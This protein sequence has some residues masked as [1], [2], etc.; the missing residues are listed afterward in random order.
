[1]EPW[2]WIALAALMLV[3]GFL[4]IER[5]PPAVVEVSFSHDDATLAGTLTLP[6]GDGPHPA[7]ILISGSGPQNRDEEIPGVPGYLPFRWIADHLARRGVAVLRYD[8]RGVG[9]S[10]GDHA[11]AT[12][13]DFADDAEAAF[14]YLQGRKEIDP[15]QV[16]FLGH[17][18]GA[19]VA[20]MV[21]ARNPDVA[22]V[23]AMAGPAVNGY[24][25][26][27]KQVERLARVGG[28]SDDQVAEALRQQRTVLDLAQA[29][30]WE[31]L[32]G[33]LHSLITAQLQGL[34]DRHKAALGDLEAIAR[35]RVAPQM[36]A[37][38]SPW[39]QF[40]LNHDPARDWEQV[41]V[42]VLALFGK[43]DVQVDV[44]QNRPPLEAAL[45]RAGNPD[46]T[47]VVFPTANHLFQSATTGGLDEY[48]VLAK[49]FVPG[50]LNTISDWLL[51]R[52]RT[53]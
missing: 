45:A 27:L 33:Y 35:Q 14:K 8:D 34:P 20:A 1:M 36:A 18:E 28:A 3:I 48:A 16:G 43:R 13:A 19:T 23:I 17:S 2:K 9:D 31:A 25:L 37:F 42:P 51:A 32:E 47:V 30:D 11:T 26:I 5:P 50:F 38:R 10:T 52:V 49:E 4:V 22:F 41:T 7:V 24:A 12:T 53:R 21:A 15:N 44:D 6:A 29:Q 39:Y 46:V 40:F